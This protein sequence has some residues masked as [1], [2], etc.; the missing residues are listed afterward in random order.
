[1]LGR[2]KLIAE[3]WDLGPDGYQAGRFPAPFAE[4]N[5]GF[6]DTVRRF[7]RGDAG[8]LP[9][10]AGRVLASAD[11]FERGG[12]RPW[13]AIN[14]V[15]AHD[16]FTTH[17]L[18]TYASKHNEANGD[19][20]RDG[21]GDEHSSNHGVEGESPD[22]HVQALRRRQHRNLLATLLL[23]QGTPMLLM[24]DEAGRSQAGNNNAYCQDNPI[25]WYPWDRITAE[26]EALT[27]FVARLVGLRRAHPALRRRHFLHGRKHGPSGLKDAA[28]IARD[29][30]ETEIEDWN[31]PGNGCL[32][33]LL[34]GAA[35]PDAGPDGRPQTDD[36]LLLLANAEPGPVAF[37]LPAAGGAAGSGWVTLIDTAN[38]SPPLLPHAAG[39]RLLL[40]AHSL[41]LL[42]ALE[43]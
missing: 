22:P 19:G 28:W 31:D 30:L 12:R 17:D 37:T 24:G 21:H 2:L 13:A 5:D 10:L 33:L 6:R 11:R 26:G 25:S 27:R 43:A 39:S 8:M 14:Y 41:R 40:A 23:A 20:N 4:W 42:R 29:G 34:D 36:V 3:P 15:A 16:G 32:G 38:D 1:V 7:W 35:A 9:A 18:V